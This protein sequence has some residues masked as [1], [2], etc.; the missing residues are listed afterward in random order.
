MG[1]GGPGGGGKETGEVYACARRYHAGSNLP[2]ACTRRMEELGS[3][4]AGLGGPEVAMATEPATPSL[5]DRY[6]T[7]WYKAGKCGI[8]ASSAL[9]RRRVATG[10]PA[11][12]CKAPMR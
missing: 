7:R 10:T 1:E 9:L 2:L 8:M 3:P 11:P 5:V 6:F 4:E 12:R